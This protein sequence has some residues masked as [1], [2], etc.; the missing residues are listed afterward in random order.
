LAIGR[1]KEKGGRQG[2]TVRQLVA[3]GWVAGWLGGWWIVAGGWLRKLG[4]VR[5]LVLRAYQVS[6][7]T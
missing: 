5:L 7:Y 2:G 1:A 4:E 3:G 6:H